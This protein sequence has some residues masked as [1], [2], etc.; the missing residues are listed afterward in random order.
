M[1]WIIKTSH[2]S[3]LTQNRLMLKSVLVSWDSFAKRGKTYL[4]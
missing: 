2:E 1:I 4:L 3:V